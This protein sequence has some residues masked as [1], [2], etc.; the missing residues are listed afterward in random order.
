MHTS[1]TS[2]LIALL[3]VFL[4]TLMLAAPASAGGWCRGDPLF[5]IGNDIVDVQVGSSL[6]M[7]QAASGPIEMVVTVRPGTTARVLLRDAGFGR[8]Y[9]IS[10]VESDALA[11]GTRAL[12]AVRAPAGGASL[13]VSVHATRLTVDIA[14]LLS[15]RP[16]IAWI[17]SAQAASDQWV[18]L[19]VR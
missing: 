15:L 18:V 17:G 13:P 5:T 14:G 12:V 3:G 1:R 4:A 7:Y 2:R 16:N 19:H 9:D 6:E 10:F 11:A 8:G